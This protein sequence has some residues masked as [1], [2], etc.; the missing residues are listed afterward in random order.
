[1]LNYKIISNSNYLNYIEKANAAY[2]VFDYKKAFSHFRR[3]LLLCNEPGTKQSILH[4]IESIQHE[5]L[6]KK[7]GVE[8]LF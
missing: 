2:E 6:R 7:T 4:M 3:A 8:S 1:M 5:Q